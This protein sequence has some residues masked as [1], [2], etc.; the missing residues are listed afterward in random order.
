MMRSYWEQLF[1]SLSS[2][3]ACDLIQTAIVRFVVLEVGNLRNNVASVA[4][5]FRSLNA[6]TTESTVRPREIDRETQNRI[7]GVPV[8]VELVS[9]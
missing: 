7:A 8:I 2:P 1:G 3:G 4:I 6:T 9:P 5:R